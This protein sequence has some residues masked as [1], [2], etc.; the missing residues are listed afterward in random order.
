V[1]SATVPTRSLTSLLVVVAATVSAAAGLVHFAAVPEHWATYRIAAVF[2]IGLGA[3][4][5][6]WASLVLGRPS[7][8]L[9]VV[10]AAA[11]LGTIA[12][13]AV[14]RTSGLPFGPFAGIA[15]RSGRADVVSTLLEEALVLALILVAYGV[16][17]QRRYGIPGYRAAVAAIAGLTG[18]LTIWAVSALSAGAHG[19]VT[20]A[21]PRVSLLSGFAGHHGL[22]LLFAGGAVA[23]YAGYLIAHIR[24]RG[25]PQFSWKLLPEGAAPG[26]DFTMPIARGDPSMSATR[27]KALSGASSTRSVPRTSPRIQASCAPMASASSP[28]APR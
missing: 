9:A 28:A 22:H 15:E 27:P 26:Q 13:W 5:I 12:I 8:A 25:W 7:R 11:S 3:F 6:V 1:N 16:G 4:Q 18:A 10:G 20:G 2:F 14:S 24:R 19:V 21:A 23:V 17:Q